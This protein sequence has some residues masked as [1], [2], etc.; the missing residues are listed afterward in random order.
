MQIFGQLEKA[1]LENTT[2]D[3][4]SLPKGMITYRTDL[5]VPKVSNGTSMLALVD[6]STAQT[7]TNKTLTSPI[8][9]GPQI[10]SGGIIHTQIATP[11]TPSAGLNKVY[12]KSDGNMYILGSDGIEKQ[13]GSGGSGTGKNYLGNINNVDGNGNFELGSTAKWS[14]F[15]T[16]L[17]SK[18]PT[19]SITAGAASLTTFAAVTSDKL[20][21]TYSLSVAS[22]GAITA[23]HGFISDAVTFDLE[24]QVKVCSFEF[25]YKAVSGTMDFSGTSN[26]TWA[27]YIYDVTNSIW[28][29]PSGV[30]GMTQGSGTGTVRGEFQTTGGTQYRLAVICVTATGG[31]TS[32][33]FDSFRMGPQSIAQGTPVSSSVSY[34]PVHTGFGTVSAVDA[35]SYRVGDRLIGSGRFTAGTPTA[36]A[37][38]LTL[39]FGGVSGNVTTNLVSNR[40]VGYWSSNVTDR[41][42]PILGIVGSNSVVFGLVDSTHGGFNT[43]NGNVISGVG[44]VITYFYDVPI[45]GWSSNVQMSQDTDTR[46]VALEATINSQS[47]PNASTTLVTGWNTPAVNT[48]GTFSGGVFT[49]PVSGLYEVKGVLGFASGTTGARYAQVN[50]NGSLYRYGL[51]LNAASTGGGATPTVAFDALVPLNAGE[52]VSISAFQSQ[53]SS[54]NL[55]TGQESHISIKR[56]SGPSVIAASETVAASMTGDPASATAGNPIIFPTAEFDTH[57]AYNTST[58][59][60]TAPISGLYDMGGYIGS[61]TS[62]VQLE[63]FVNGSFVKRVGYTDSAGEATISGLVKLNAGDILDLRPAGSTLDANANS[64][65]SI[66]RIK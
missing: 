13:I 64:T 12:T 3:T 23:G 40:I 2:S 30:Y 48:H 33:L 20:A 8:L 26:N 49:A 5:N 43:A 46:V 38:A 37:S 45:V 28:I 35:S 7:L 4:G 66:K 53:G 62:G 18:I 47:I 6:E 63:A 36:V 1:Q 50:K 19:G 31:A 15:N 17:T 22:S 14:L 44:D 54:L 39:G 58:G 9:T 29:Q 41:H 65:M 57:G 55:A 24:D 51:Q 11:S 21:G 10:T 61:G 25:S 16:T 52:T 59:R 27:V 34:T 32:M 60:Y 42:G 56:L